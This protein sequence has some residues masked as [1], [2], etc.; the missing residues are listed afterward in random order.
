MKERLKNA[1]SQQR[2][3]SPTAV[4][5]TKTA[6]GLRPRAVERYAMIFDTN[7]KARL[8]IITR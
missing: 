8:G 1:I 3:E 2:P 5:Q 7:P 6:L 4:R